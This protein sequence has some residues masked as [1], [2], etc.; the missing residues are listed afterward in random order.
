M[1]SL[2]DTELVREFAGIDD[3]AFDTLL[4]SIVEGV[5][6]RVENLMRRTIRA[7]N[8]DETYVS[9]GNSAIVLDNGPIIQVPSTE[10]DAAE[11]TEG[12][13]VLTS[14]DYRIEGQS[15]IRLSGG[16]TAAW[17]TGDV[18]I[19]YRAGWEYEDIPKD[20]Q[21]EI[22]KQAAWEWK[23]SKPG[24][25]RLGLSG[26]DNPNGSAVYIDL[27]DGLIPSLV[28]LVNS[29]RYQSVL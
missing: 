13:G 6:S 11:P 20:L 3:G 22:A 21:L 17:A 16:V 1:A 27:V 12:T 26:K 29:P 5:G 9:T 19:S 2:V 10:T 7:T 18:T 4:E 28:S 25:N 23:Q 15:L 14:D 8:Y 24:G